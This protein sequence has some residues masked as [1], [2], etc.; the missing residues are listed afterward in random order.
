MFLYAAINSFKTIISA[1]E[2]PVKDLEVW[3]NFDVL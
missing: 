1:T 3:S 2:E